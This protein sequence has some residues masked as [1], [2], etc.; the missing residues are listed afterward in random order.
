[1]LYMFGK[2]SSSHCYAP[3]DMYRCDLAFSRYSWSKF[4][5]LGLLGGTPEGILYVRDIVLNF[6]PIGVT[7]GEIS[8][9]EQI[10]RYKELQ[11]MVDQTK[12]ILG[13][14]FSIISNIRTK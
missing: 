5:I 13:L 12:R 1:M 7:T 11:H 14:R 10:Q 2:L 9:T 3:F 4:G 6:T 8:V